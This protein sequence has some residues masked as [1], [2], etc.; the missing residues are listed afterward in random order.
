VFLDVADPR[1]NGL[2]A[3]SLSVD[4]FAVLDDPHAVWGAGGV[5][6]GAPVAVDSE[7]VRVSRDG[8][9]TFLPAGVSD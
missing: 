4:D 3:E 7:T 8:V 9:D 1:R 6:V 5:V 2:A